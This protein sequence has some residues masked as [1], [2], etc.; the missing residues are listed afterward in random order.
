VIVQGIEASAML[1]QASC[2]LCESKLIQV[3]TD[4][5]YAPAY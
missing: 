3:H 2:Q 1:G 5:S 4:V